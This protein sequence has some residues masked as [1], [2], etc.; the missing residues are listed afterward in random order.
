MV[1]FAFSSAN[2]LESELNLSSMLITGRNGISKDFLKIYE[3]GQT[4]ILWYQEMNRLVFNFEK[5]TTANKSKALDEE[6]LH[7]L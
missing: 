7:F 3:G 2:Y 6:S 5:K 4:Q 1:W